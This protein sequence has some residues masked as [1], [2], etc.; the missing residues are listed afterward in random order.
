[1]MTNKLESMIKALSGPPESMNAERRR[2]LRDAALLEIAT[3]AAPPETAEGEVAQA[4]DPLPSRS[5][6]SV[7]EKTAF[8][9]ANGSDAFLALPG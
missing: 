9:S 2:Q 1:M 4:P 8:I 6:M 7:D 5:T 3:L